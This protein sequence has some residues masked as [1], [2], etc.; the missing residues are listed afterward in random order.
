MQYEISNWARRS[1]VTGLPIYQSS[2]LLNLNPALACQHNLTYWRNKS[3]LGF[4]PGAHSI[5][6]GAGA[7]RI[8]SPWRSTSNGLAGMILRVR[9]VCSIRIAPLRSMAA[10]AAG[11]ISPSRIDNRLAIGETG[12]FL[13]CVWYHEG[14]AYDRFLQRHGTPLL[15]LFSADIRDLVALGLLDVLPD[16]VRLTHHAPGS[17]PDFSRFLP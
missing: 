5:R 15:D 10:V 3:Y 12:T 8:S 7:G 16:R 1:E 2:N 14:V 11:W 13:D 6:K 17:Q 9:L 4:G